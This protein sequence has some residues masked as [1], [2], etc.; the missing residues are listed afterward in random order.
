MAGG[1]EGGGGS[2]EGGGG[3]GGGGEG[4]MGDVTRKCV[5]PENTICFYRGTRCFGGRGGG[6]FNSL[7]TRE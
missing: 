6:S 1:R 7:L 4:G 2:G 5:V 3:G